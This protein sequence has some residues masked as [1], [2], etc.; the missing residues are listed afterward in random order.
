MIPGTTD[1]SVCIQKK[2]H[3]IPGTTGL[4]IWIQREHA[5]INLLL[6]EPITLMQFPASA[7]RCKSVCS[8]GW[9]AFS[10]PEGDVSSPP[11]HFLTGQ[12]SRRSLRVSST[13]R[14]RIGSERSVPIGRAITLRPAGV[15]PRGSPEEQASRIPGTRDTA[16][17]RSFHARRE[18]PRSRDV[19]PPLVVS[20]SHK[21]MLPGT[22]RN[23]RFYLLGAD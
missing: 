22:N 16:E 13:G 23:H 2:D 9:R 11:S 5:V 4:W 21:E 8:Q 20:F 12:D 3:M 6:L 1:L 18:P 19:Y 14:S 15:R 17:S 7:S 10:S